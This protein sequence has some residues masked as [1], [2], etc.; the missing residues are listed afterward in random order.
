VPVRLVTVRVDGGTRAGR[1]EGASIQLLPY[2]DV[3]ALLADPQWR[4][5]AATG[6]G[7]EPYE[8]ARLAPVVPRPGKIIC[9]GLNYRRHIEEMGRAMPE[10]P[11]LFAKFPAALIGA[12]DPIV[13]P[14]VATSVDWEVELG[15]V[16]GRHARHV[17]AV[18]AASAIA[19]YT[20]VNDIS[21]RDYQRRTLQWLQ[22]K[23]FECMTP[24]GPAL[25]SPDEVDGARDLEV[26]CEVDGDVKQRARTSDLLFSPAQ[27][28]SYISDIITLEPGDL[29]ST[30]TP[31][32][33]GEARTPPEFLRA[34]QVV[35]STIHGIGSLV[36]VC[37]AEPA[38]R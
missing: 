32:G 27:I 16:I 37:E 23:T 11:T 12:R 30:G 29:I 14:A 1:V 22:G 28:V 18:D 7:T 13:L 8:E 19:G 33:V 36:N 20:V 38:P 3:G 6:I 25:V 5:R 15:V 34:G 24:V 31:G 4:D 9:L 26:M 2:P 21:V 17:S 35:T 10:H